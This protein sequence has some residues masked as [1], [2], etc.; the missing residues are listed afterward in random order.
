MKKFWHD[1]DIQLFIGNLLRAGVLSSSVV[2]IIGGVF[3]LLHQGRQPASYSEFN[4]SGGLHTFTA[5]LEGVVNGRGSAIIQLG[6][7][8]LITTPVARILFSI[9]GFLQEKDR[10]YVF[11]TSLVLIIIFTSVLLG[12]KA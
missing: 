12:L 11:I 6:V 3:Y 8:L 9:F 7:L 5:V 10:M 4:G 2:I 1:K